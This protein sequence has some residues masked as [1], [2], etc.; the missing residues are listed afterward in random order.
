MY[1]LQPKNIPLTF[2]GNLKDCW[3]EKFCPS[4]VQRKKSYVWQPKFLI[5][6]K[7]LIYPFTYTW[8]F[9]RHPITKF[10]KASSLFKPENQ[11]LYA[12]AE[13][14]IFIPP[15]IQRKNWA[16]LCAEKQKRPTHPRTTKR[17]VQS[18]SRLVRIVHV[19]ISLWIAPFVFRFLSHGLVG[20]LSKHNVFYL[21]SQ[22]EKIAFSL[23]TVEQILI[24]E[25]IN[26][27]GIP[28]GVSHWLL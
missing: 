10:Q 4:L 25:K 27:I 2:H 17:G 20:A 5:V 19:C 11:R 8:E 6:Y 16:P 15:L 22:N 28:D 23:S 14:K 1:R 7:K 12:Q 3:A 26:A 21:S 24:C 18:A 13:Q 9:T